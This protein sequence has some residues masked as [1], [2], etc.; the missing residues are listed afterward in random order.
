MGWYGLQIPSNRQ[1]LS[2]AVCPAYQVPLLVGLSSE[3]RVEEEDGASAELPGRD[4][5]SGALVRLYSTIRASL[6][7]H[8]RIECYLLALQGPLHR[9]LRL[10]S[11]QQAIG[12]ARI[13]HRCSFG[14]ACEVN[15]GF[16]P[17]DEQLRLL[18]WRRRSQLQRRGF[19]NGLYLQCS[20][21]RTTRS[22]LEDMV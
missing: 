15:E 18:Q 16:G 9:I 13:F 20:S 21:R 8:P 10:R 19:G 12:R 6:I 5:R 2:A 4:F 17:L 1:L 22:V 3:G 7:C 11:S 14:E